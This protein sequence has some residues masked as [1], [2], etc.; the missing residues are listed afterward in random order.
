M[1]LIKYYEDMRKKKKKKSAQ[2]NQTL[3]YSKIVNFDFMVTL[4]VMDWYIS[5]YLTILR[6][7]HWP[8]IVVFLLPTA[9]S[10]LLLLNYFVIIEIISHPTLQT[11]TTAPE[12]N[13]CWP[14]IL[15]QNSMTDFLLWKIFLSYV[16]GFVH[17]IEVNF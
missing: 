1:F 13:S 16:S 6:L 14:L 3:Q 17:R 11:S 8:L 4:I 15:N 7:S 10:N 9:L 5:W 2:I 12:K